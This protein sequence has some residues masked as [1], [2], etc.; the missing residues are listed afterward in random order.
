MEI[1]Q[2]GETIVRKEVTER[3]FSTRSFALPRRWGAFHEI[4]DLRGVEG[5]A[6]QTHLV[7]DPPEETA[8]VAVELAD[9]QR[10]VRIRY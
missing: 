9:D 8:C 7:D 3:P 2:A 5:A 4:N 6:V 10:A 1:Q